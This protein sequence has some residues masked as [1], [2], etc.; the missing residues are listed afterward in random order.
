MKK[1]LAY[2]LSFALLLAVAVPVTQ[3][4]AHAEAKK[5]KNCTELNKDYK[6]GVAKSAD[7]KNKGG[8]TKHKPFVSAELYEANKTKDRD[9]DFIACE[10]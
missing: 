3:Q 6:G 1:G 7:I 9:K 2:S 8:K 4:T 10:K 5:Y